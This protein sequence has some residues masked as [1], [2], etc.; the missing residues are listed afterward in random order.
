MAPTSWVLLWRHGFPWDV[1]MLA[2]TTGNLPNTTFKRFNILSKGRM[3]SFSATAFRGCNWSKKCLR[4]EFLPNRKHCLIIKTDRL[5]L[6]REIIAVQTNSC[7][8]EKVGEIRVTRRTVNTVSAELSS[9]WRDTSA[10]FR[11]IQRGS[12]ESPHPSSCTAREH[13]SGLS[14]V[15]S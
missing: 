2:R 10:P 3:V 8:K 6:S 9:N 7:N 14:C 15:C 4:I 5:M 13:K 12:L 1:R 11:N